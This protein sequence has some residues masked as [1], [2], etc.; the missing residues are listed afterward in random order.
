MWG[1]IIITLRGAWAQYSDEE[2]F[3]RSIFEEVVRFVVRFSF[4]Q[5]FDVA[6]LEMSL[7]FSNYIL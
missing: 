3:S 2:M 5:R 7:N 1:T 4:S 6:F